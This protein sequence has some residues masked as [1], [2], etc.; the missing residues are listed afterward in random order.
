MTYDFDPYQHSQ[1]T[2][3]CVMCK[4][5][6]PKTGAYFRKTVGTVI[7]KKCRKCT[8]TPAIKSLDIKHRAPSTKGFE[9]FCTPR[10]R[11]GK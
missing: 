3:V 6:K 4:Q 11:R 8:R 10:G 7:S 2:Q 9:W 1:K 5:E